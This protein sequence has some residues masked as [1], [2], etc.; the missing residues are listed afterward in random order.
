MMHPRS[1][2]CLSLDAALPSVC[3][4]F[5]F[6]LFLG[7]ASP[8]SALPEFGGA[9]KQLGLTSAVLTVV[10]RLPEHVQVDDPAAQRKLAKKLER[11]QVGGGLGDRL[12][13]QGSCATEGLAGYMVGPGL[14]L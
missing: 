6:C 2:F 3:L 8:C 12:H 5:G 4:W 1:G 7:A 13:T 10:K 11:Q 14:A 9:P